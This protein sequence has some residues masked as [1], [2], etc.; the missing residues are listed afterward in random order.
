VQTQVVESKPAGSVAYLQVLA[1]GRTAEDARR[2]ATQVL[3][4]VEKRHAD[5]ARTL[6]E[7]TSDYQ[8]ALATTVK[9]L[10]EGVTRLEGIIAQIRPGAPDAGLAAVV[11]QS[12]LES[13][14]SQYID[15]SRDLRDA[16][17]KRVRG[18]KP[19]K[20][21]APPALPSRPVWPS[22]LVFAVV[23]GGLG[24][25]AAAIWILLLG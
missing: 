12:Q 16:K 19:T 8:D 23:G 15:L 10:G 22:R 7:E 21:L 2:L 5:I 18:S 4:F 9:Q 20:E 11:L 6:L 14:R 25:A 24:L 3:D 17:M 13:K 1:R